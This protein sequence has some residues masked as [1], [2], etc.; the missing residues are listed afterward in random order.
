MFLHNPA[1]TVI[2]INN[3][4]VLEAPHDLGAGP[5]KTIDQP[6]GFGQ[7]VFMLFTTGY[8][9]LTPNGRTTGK[10]GDIVINSPLF[11]QW[12][13]G[14]DTPFHNYW[15]HFQGKNVADV[16]QKYEIDLNVPLRIVS[17]FK[18][19]PG[20][21]EMQREF[22]F[23]EAYWDEAIDN[24]FNSLFREIGRQLQLRHDNNYSELEWHYLDRFRDLRLQL[25]QRF[26]EEWTVRKI[27]DIVNMSESRMLHLYKKFFDI[28]PIEDLIHA[29]IERS[30]S[31][32]AAR[33]GNV[34]AIAEECGFASVYYFSRIFKQHTG[35]SPKAYVPPTRSVG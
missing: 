25:W 22:N 8:K 32:L 34:S 23:R 21:V 4:H 18:C 33:H 14:V 31:L 28:S 11:P 3:I 29:R 35:Q 5:G 24:L 7:W 17:P 9:L 1:N 15:I 26:K 13:Q 20:L 30:K 27:A 16:L 19:L 10:P 2:Y 6:N 12:H